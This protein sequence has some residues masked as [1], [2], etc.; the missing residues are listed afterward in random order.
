MGCPSLSGIG[1]FDNK[2]AGIDKTV[3]LTNSS[4]AGVDSG[5]YILD[6]ASGSMTDLAT[7]TPLA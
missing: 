6:P 3:T 1:T 5:N 7:I 4:L 2:N